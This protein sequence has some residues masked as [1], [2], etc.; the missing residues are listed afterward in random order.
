MI[1][2]PYNHDTDKDAVHRIWREVGWLDKG[3]EEAMD[4]IV[5]AGRATVAELDGSAECMVLT[6]PGA[7]R[8]L[9]CDLPFCGVTGVTTSH[10]ARKQGLASRTAAQAESAAALM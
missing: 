5:T 10:V 2:R 8:Y 7:V 9:D 4:H 6:A 3:E 1:I